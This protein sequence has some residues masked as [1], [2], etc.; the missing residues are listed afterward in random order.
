MALRYTISRYIQVQ[1]NKIVSCEALVR[2]KDEKLGFIP[3]QEFIPIA[4]EK[5]Q[6]TQNR[7]ICFRGSLPLYKE[8]RGNFTWYRICAGKPIGS[9]VYAI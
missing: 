7:Q 3:P 5:R 9:P 6:D 4:E 8:R 2:L 1:R